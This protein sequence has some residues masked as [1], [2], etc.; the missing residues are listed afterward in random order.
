MESRDSI[1]LS[2]VVVMASLR[3]ALGARLTGLS[4]PDPFPL[5]GDS[6]PESMEVSEPLELSPLARGSSIV[7]EYVQGLCVCVIAMAASC[8]KE[9]ELCTLERG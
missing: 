5:S 7:E 6:K 3:Q 9:T 2:P 1:V 4:L 8:Y